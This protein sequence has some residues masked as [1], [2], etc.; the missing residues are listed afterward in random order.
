MV[1]QTRRI[2]LP[3]LNANQLLTDFLIYLEKNEY[4]DTSYSP[5]EEVYPEILKE[6]WDT[7]LRESNHN[8]HV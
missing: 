8:G 1:Y 5:P 3:M 2:G 6:Y 4:I 7:H